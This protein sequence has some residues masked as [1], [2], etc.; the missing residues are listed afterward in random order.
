M[1]DFLQQCAAATRLAELNKSIC[2]IIRESNNAAAKFRQ[3][4]VVFTQ[5]RYQRLS[6]EMELS[7]EKKKKK[8]EFLQIYNI[9]FSA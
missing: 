8:K 3:A 4:A 7:D 9:P 6:S 5:L 1:T 2:V